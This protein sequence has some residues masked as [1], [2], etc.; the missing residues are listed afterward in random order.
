MSGVSA[1][2]MAKPKHGKKLEHLIGRPLVPFFDDTV[3]DSC[4]PPF[5]MSV[6]PDWAHTT[7]TSTPCVIPPPLPRARK[8]SRR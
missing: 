5:P 8:M 3:G 1:H 4:G 6:V 7:L 2:M